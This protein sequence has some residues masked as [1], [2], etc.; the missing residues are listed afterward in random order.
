MSK[1]CVRCYH[2]FDENEPNCPNCGLTA[3]PTKADFEEKFDVID[4]HLLQHPEE[5]KPFFLSCK[6]SYALTCVF[7]TLINVVV[8][9]NIDIKAFTY[10]I[11]MLVIAHNLYLSNSSKIKKISHKIKNYDYYYGGLRGLNSVSWALGTMLIVWIF[12]SR[13]DLFGGFYIELYYVM[14]VVYVIM[15]LVF[16]WTASKA[17]RRL[18]KFAALVKTSG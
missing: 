6:I 8:Y 9:F 4:E 11:I 17:Q 18:L 5:I 2:E 12:A 16:Y 3:G 10:A 1:V 14:F 15:I 13:Y 7:F